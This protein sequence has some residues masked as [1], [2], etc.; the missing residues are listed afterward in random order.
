MNRIIVAVVWMIITFRMPGKGMWEIE[1]NGENH[2]NQ[3]K[4][5][6]AGEFQGTQIV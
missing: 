1:R 2:E 5:N 3:T 4:L 6:Q